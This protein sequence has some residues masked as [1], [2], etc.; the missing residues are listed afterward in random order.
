MTSSQARS[1]WGSL[2][3]S[4]SNIVDERAWSRALIFSKASE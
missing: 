3:S 1:M 2:L 4:P